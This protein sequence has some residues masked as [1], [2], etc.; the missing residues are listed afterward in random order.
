M[1]V[2]GDYKLWIFSVNRNLAIFKDSRKIPVLKDKLNIC[3]RCKGIYVSFWVG[4]SILSDILLG[5]V[6]L[7]LFTE[8]IIASISDLDLGVMVKES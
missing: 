5:P 7:L 6:A 8:E 4:L 2:I 1:P 3:A